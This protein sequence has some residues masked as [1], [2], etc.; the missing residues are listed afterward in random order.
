[1]IRTGAAGAAPMLLDRALRERV[2]RQVIWAR[3]PRW[4]DDALG[5]VAAHEEALLWADERVIQHRSMRAITRIP[6]GGGAVAVKQFRSRGVG[7][8][9]ALRGGSRA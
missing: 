7:R 4:L 1:V 3:D 6:T 2:G 9:P 8:W 5:V